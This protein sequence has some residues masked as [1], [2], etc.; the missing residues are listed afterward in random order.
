MA[1]VM[2]VIQDVNDNAPTFYPSQYSV[3][4]DLDTITRDHQV[5]VVRATD[6]DSGMYGTV[7]YGIVGGNAEG[8]FTI[9]SGTGRHDYVSQV[10][11]LFSCL[12]H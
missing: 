10:T 12:G 6:S 1:L 2:I 8:I 11:S 9:D 5:V 3:S 4:L 7:S